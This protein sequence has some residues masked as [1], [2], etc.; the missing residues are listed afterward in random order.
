MMEAGQGNATMM[1][2][3]SHPLGVAVEVSVGYGPS[4]RVYRISSV[5]LI[6]D[7]SRVYDPPWIPDFQHGKIIN[8]PF[9]KPSSL[10]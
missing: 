5:L 10:W 6:L 3:L 2:E 8:L 9:F 7:F 1:K 4:S